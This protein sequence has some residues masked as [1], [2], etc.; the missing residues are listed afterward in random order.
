VPSTRARLQAATPWWAATLL[1]CLLVTHTGKLLWPLLPLASYIQFPWRLLGLVAVCGAVA[2][3]VSWAGLIRT[4][5][6]R[7]LL[8][9]CR[10]GRGLVGPTPCAGRETSRRLRAVRRRRGHLH[11]RLGTKPHGEG[12]HQRALAFTHAPR[13]PPSAAARRLGKSR[14]RSRTRLTG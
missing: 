14:A 3:G 7:W 1:L 6:P 4:D 13:E 5:A 9:S 2:V 11:V 10:G 12:F 8:A